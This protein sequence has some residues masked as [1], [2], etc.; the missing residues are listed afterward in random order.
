MKQKK[1]VQGSEEAQ[2]VIKNL[3]AHLELA[4]RIEENL[5]YKKK[6]LEANIVAKK[7]EEE[8]REKILKNHRKERINDLN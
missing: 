3:R 7:E 4:R 1:S 5:E 6:C 8:K 2:Q